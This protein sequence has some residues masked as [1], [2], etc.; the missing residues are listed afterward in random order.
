MGA[1]GGRFSV[2]EYL[3]GACGSMAS[4]EMVEAHAAI[5]ADMQS[6]AVQCARE[7]LVQLLPLLNMGSVFRQS[8]VKRILL[9]RGLIQSD[10]FRDANPPLDSQDAAEIDWIYASLEHLMTA[11]VRPPKEVH[12][13]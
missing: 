10:H 13:L 9:K 6:G 8:A 5:W 11:T 3:R 1:V 2:D 7:R 4:C 12:A